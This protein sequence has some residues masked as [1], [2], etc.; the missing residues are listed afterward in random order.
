MLDNGPSCAHKNANVARA[1]FEF[2]PSFHC[3]V[4]LPSHSIEYGCQKGKNIS[5]LIPA[6]HS[7]S[8][9][10]QDRKLSYSVKVIV[11]SYGV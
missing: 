5:S 3:V 7:W 10:T 2:D 9:S 1:E 8:V 6:K 4:L 11:P